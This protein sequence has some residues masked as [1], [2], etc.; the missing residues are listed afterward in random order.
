[1]AR[2]WESKSVESQIEDADRRAQR[3]DSL[4]PE[5]RERQQKRAGLELSR[6]RVL[7]DIAAARSDVRRA[8]LEQALAF[9][10]GEIKK[11]DF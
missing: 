11:L 10:D 8:S 6:R 5:E 7:T 1:M 4:T 2:G 3:G 9:L